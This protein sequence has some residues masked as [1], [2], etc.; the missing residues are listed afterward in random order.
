MSLDR[1]RAHLASR[2]RFLA[3][4]MAG[5]Y[6]VLNILLAALAPLTAG[7]PTVAV[8][9]VA[10]P[11]MVLAMVYAVIPVARRFGAPRG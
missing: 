11:P 10:V 7:W 1:L 9:G 5:A 3:I 2:F 6:T 4:A 8:T